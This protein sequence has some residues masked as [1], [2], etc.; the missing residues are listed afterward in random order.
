MRIGPWLSFY[1]ES[2]IHVGLAVISLLGITALE[3][4]TSLGFQVY[5]LVFCATVVGYNFIR[6]YRS[7]KKGL[8]DLPEPQSLFW[9]INIVAC[10]GLVIFSFYLDPDLLIVLGVLGAITLFYD[11][12]LNESRRP[13]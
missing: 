11:F 6:Y 3:L 7:Y 5:L 1:V 10:I 4:N 9:L 13:N 8:G 12:P 2:S